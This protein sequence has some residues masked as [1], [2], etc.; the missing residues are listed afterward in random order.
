MKDFFILLCL[1]CLIFVTIMIVFY[2]VKKNLVIKIEKSTN[3]E[4]SNDQE[5]VEFIKKHSDDEEFVEFVDESLNNSEENNDK[6][7]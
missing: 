5:F 2:I 4:I 3:N 7:I 6:N 1:F